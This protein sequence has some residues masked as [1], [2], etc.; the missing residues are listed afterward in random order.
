LTP[1]TER[2]FERVKLGMTAQEV[3]NILGKPVEDYPDVMNWH[4]PGITIDVHF[5][6]RRVTDKGCVPSDNIPS[7]RIWRRSVDENSHRGVDS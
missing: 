1:V 6:D 5:A 2:N 7:W 4:G 3:I